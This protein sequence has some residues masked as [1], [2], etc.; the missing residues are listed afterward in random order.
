MADSFTPDDLARIQRETFIER[1]EYHAE[2]E[3]TNTRALELCRTGEADEMLLV[4]AD[5]QTAGRGRQSNQWW[6]GDGALTFSLILATD[7]A[8]L[9]AERWPQA[10]LTTGLAVCEAVS[11]LLP[12]AEVALKWPND[13]YLRRRKVCG[14]LIEIPP[15]KPGVLVVGIGINVNNALA[16]A[17]AE[18]QH[19]ATSLTDCTGLDHDRSDV[20]ILIV[21]QL[22]LELER[23]ARGDASLAERWRR[24]CHLRGKQVE[25]LAG[26]RR[27]A[28]RCGGIGP[29]GGLILETDAGPTSFF[30]G[31]ITSVRATGNSDDA[32]SR[33]S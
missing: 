13:V 33:E 19:T 21:Q 22:Q 32:S 6:A 5:R 23:L 15:E 7:S 29:D 24:L 27:Y 9:P 12:T 3:S 4:L 26:E 2:I 11:N 1:C 20:L 14:V 18:L 17:P 8:N 16:A 10:S 30:G 25:L 31:V 28:G